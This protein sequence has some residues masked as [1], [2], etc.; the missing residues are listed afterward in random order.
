MERVKSSLQVMYDNSP[1]FK[2]RFTDIYRTV[3]RI[4]LR[5]ASK[6]GRL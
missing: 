5:G 4:D 2:A 1:L 6:D 3:K